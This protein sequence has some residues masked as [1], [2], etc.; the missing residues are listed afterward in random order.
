MKIIRT[1]L[2]ASVI[3]FVSACTTVIGTSTDFTRWSGSGTYVGSGGLL[4]EH[5]GVEFWRS[6]APEAEFYIVGMITQNKSANT[7]HDAMFGGVN[8]REILNIVKSNNADGV[9]R[10]DSQ[11]YISGYTTTVPQS[12]PSSANTR[13]NMREE[14]SMF[15]FKYVE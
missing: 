5:D 7:M 2:L 3:I 1:C 4:D 9:I 8:R 12:M 6:G 10:A 13:A 15:V 11:R 14:S